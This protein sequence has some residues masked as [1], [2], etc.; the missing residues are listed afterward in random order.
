MS[1]RRTAWLEWW[2][3]GLL[4]GFGL[5]MLFSLVALGYIP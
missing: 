2:L 3:P 5:G 1:S 4:V